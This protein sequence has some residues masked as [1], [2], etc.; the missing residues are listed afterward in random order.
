MDRSVLTI[1]EFT[2]KAKGILEANFFD[3]WLIG[4]ISN[5]RRPASGHCYFTLKD[6][7]CQLKGVV[8]RGQASKMKFELEDGLKVIVHGQVSIYEQRGEYQ[9]IIDKLEPAG[10]GDLQLAFEQLKQKLSEEGLFNTEHKKPIPPFPQKI[11]VVT[12]S[13]GAAFRDILNIIDRRYRNVHVILYPSR[14]QGEEAA[15]EIVRGIRYF[16]THHP[17]D[18]LI[19]GRGGGSL[20]D[21]WAFNEEIVARAIFNSEIPIV[22]AVG[23]EIDFTISDFIADLRAP[24][25]SAAAELVVQNKAEIKNR[26]RNLEYQIVNRIKSKLTSFKHDLMSLVKSASFFEPRNSLSQKRQY[27]DDLSERLVIYLRRIQTEESHYLKNLSQRILTH[28]P[29]N[30]LPVMQSRFAGLTEKLKGSL[31]LSLAN[32]QSRFEAII[33]QLNALS[34]LSTLER[35]YAICWKLPKKLIVTSSHQVNQDDKLCVKL[36]SGE[37]LCRVEGKND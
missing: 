1:S 8:F 36:S 21:L 24:T 22:S 32:Q 30:Q 4:E 35:G 19:I 11:G 6:E 10:L 7:K 34:P 26:I 25:P 16:N 33:R 13:T 20:E 12:S 15:G 9:I 28:S 18:V 23:H 29:A 31:H 27:L 37:I 2:R 14:V 5:F 3:I 17:V